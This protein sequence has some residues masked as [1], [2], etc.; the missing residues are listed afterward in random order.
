MTNDIGEFRLFAIPPG[1]YYLSATLRSMGMMGDT[2]DRSGYAPTYFPGTAEHGRSAEG[3]DR[4]RPDGQRHQHG[5]DADAHRADHRHR[6]RFQGRPMM[7]MVMAM[8]RGDSMMMMFGPPGQI[9]P[10]GTFS[11]GGLAPGTYVL[12]TQGGGGPDGESASAEVTLSGDDVS[13]IRLVGS[14]PS[15][16]SGRVVVDAGVGRGAAAVDAAH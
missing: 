6:R 15:T 10:D 9:K 3:H 1:Q 12:Q 7:G 16:A 14:K 4:P 2:D 8:P 11:I 13:G 5:A